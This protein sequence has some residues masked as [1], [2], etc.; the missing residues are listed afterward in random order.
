MLLAKA[1]G[2][3]LAAAIAAPILIVLNEGTDELLN[4]LCIL[5]VLLGLGLSFL[6]KWCSKKIS[7][8]RWG[9]QPKK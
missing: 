3:T 5:T 8:E 7:P 1:S 6:C 4:P 2:A 9:I